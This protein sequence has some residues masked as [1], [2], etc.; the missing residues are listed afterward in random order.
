MSASLS[1]F[2]YTLSPSAGGFHAQELFTATDTTGVRWN[3]NCH[4]SSLPHGGTVEDGFYSA[5]PS[6]QSA[7]AG[8]DPRLPMP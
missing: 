4:C 8:L 2:S 1:L 5:C 7:F 3:Y 6:P